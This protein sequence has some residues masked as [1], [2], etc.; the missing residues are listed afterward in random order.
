MHSSRPFPVHY[1]ICSLQNITSAIHTIPK[2]VFSPYTQVCLGAFSCQYRQLYFDSILLNYCRSIVICG[3]ARSSFVLPFLSNGFLGCFHICHLY[4]Q[5]CFEPFWIHLYFSQV[6]VRNYS[7]WAVGHAYVS[8]SLPD[9]T[10]QVGFYYIIL[11]ILL[12]I[13]YLFSFFIGFTS[14]GHQ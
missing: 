12:M 7:C 9:C 11:P 4:K 3:L 13:I 1:N 8:L 14:I 2:L 5:W 6:S 10:L